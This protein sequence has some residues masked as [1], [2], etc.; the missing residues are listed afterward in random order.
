MYSCGALHMDEQ[1]QDDQHEPTYT[2]SVPIRDLALKTY[3]KQSVFTNYIYLIYMYKQNL[4]LNNQEGLMCHK[5]H[6]SN[7]QKTMPF[8]RMSAENY[9]SFDIYIRRS[10]NNFLDFFR[11]GTFID[12]THMKL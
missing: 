7:Q 5:T 10:L 3:R 11:L 6:T 12:S 8:S 2:S 1:R 9:S 4:A